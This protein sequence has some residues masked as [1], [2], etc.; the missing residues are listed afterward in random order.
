[1][2]EQGLKMV[3]RPLTWKNEGRNGSLPTPSKLTQ[4]QKEDNIS[5][6]FKNL[7][8]IALLLI[9]LPSQ[10]TPKSPRATSSFSMTTSSGKSVQAAPIPI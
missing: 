9:N 6:G 3:P 10:R 8:S 1:M 5:A 7:F 4:G 2:K